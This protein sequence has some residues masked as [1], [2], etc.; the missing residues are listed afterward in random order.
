MLDFFESKQQQFCFISKSNLSK[1]DKDF[2]TTFTV[3]KENKALL[4]ITNT[5]PALR[6]PT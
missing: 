3:L 5:S 2:H 4:L 6:D 1:L